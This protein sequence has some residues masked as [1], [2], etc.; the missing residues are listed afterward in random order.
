LA[1]YEEL[2]PKES[3]T[4]RPEPDEQVSP[5]S[6]YEPLELGPSDLP[7]TEETLT[8]GF[9][10]R[11]ETQDAKLI[12]ELAA[13]HTQVQAAAAAHV[14][15]RTVYRRLQEPGFQARVRARKDELFSQSVDQAVALLPKAIS[16]IARVVTAGED[17]AV[18]VRAAKVAVDVATRLR[19]LDVG[20]RLVELEVRLEAL[21]AESDGAN[22]QSPGTAGSASP[23]GGPHP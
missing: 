14:S 4:I 8:S 7:A 12:E 3:G 6:A 2:N 1:G 20:G 22:P 17:D 18:R 15:V 5:L 9:D 23:T 21:G 19:A 16:A 10:L 13:G 11:R